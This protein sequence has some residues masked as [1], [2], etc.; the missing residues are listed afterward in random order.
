MNANVIAN[1]EAEVDSA[2]EC[3]ESPAGDLEQLAYSAEDLSAYYYE[4]ECL[5][6]RVEKAETHY[7]VLRIDYLATDDET[8]DAYLK[9]MILLDPATYGLNLESAEELGPRVALAS[10]RVLAA[11]Q[12]LMD[13]DQRLEYDRQL[14]GWE[15]EESKRAKPDHQ[16]K[17]SRAGGTNNERGKPN[18]RERERFE[19]SI[20]VEVTGYNENSSDW[21]EAVQ[22]LDLN[23]SGGRI[24]LRRRVLVGNIL[25]LR[26]PMPTV[27]RKH[28]YID[29]IYGTYAIVRWIRPPRDGF[30]LVGVEFIGEVPP[31]GFPE[32]PWATFHISRRQAGERRAEPRD[33]LSE[34]IEIEYFDESEQLIMKNSG[35]MEDISNSGARVCAQQPPSD[36][37]LIRIIRPKLS[38]SLFALVRNRFKG[39]DGYE[40]LC[41]Q[42]ISELTAGG[43]QDH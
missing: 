36:A 1:M 24:L 29:Q 19:L 43:A 21:R 32:R 41:V 40:R 10:E 27:L 35:F 18:R 4:L 42:F 9:A 17:I 26:M 14:F 8:I 28:E 38:V 22:S 23:R 39:R 2:H 15:N 20:P 5:L 6:V 25:F 12:T 31:P 37:D 13:F 3:Q 30:R 7:G 34:A 33:G 16:R 11:Y